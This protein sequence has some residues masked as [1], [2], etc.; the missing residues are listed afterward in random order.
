MKE[1]A[2]SLQSSQSASPSAKRVLHAQHR[3]RVATAPFPSP[4][5]PVPGPTGAQD[6]R[7]AEAPYW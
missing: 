6:T 7:A 2:G 5:S 3:K 4:Q 1:R